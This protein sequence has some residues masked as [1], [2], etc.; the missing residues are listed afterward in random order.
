MVAYHEL[1]AVRRVPFY[2]KAQYISHAVSCPV[3]NFVVR[4]VW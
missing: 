2:Q 4:I 3:V 1:Y